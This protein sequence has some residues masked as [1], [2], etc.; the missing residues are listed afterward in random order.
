M[1]K[2]SN[3]NLFYKIE[4]FHGIAIYCI[5]PI[6]LFLLFIKTNNPIWP[7]FFLIDLLAPF[8]HLV[9]TLIIPKRINKFFKTHSKDIKCIK[10]EVVGFKF[11]TPRRY[12]EK[13]MWIVLKFEEKQYYMLSEEIF[14]KVLLK[15]R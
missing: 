6:L 15:L 3:D 10:A 14:N 9:I 7:I 4:I 8:I 13:R 5:I 1:Q 12:R 11:F 2:K